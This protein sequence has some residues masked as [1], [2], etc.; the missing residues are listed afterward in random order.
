MPPERQRRFPGRKSPSSLSKNLSQALLHDFGFQV[1]VL[2]KTAKEMKYVIE[3]NP[4]LK[5]R[6]IDRNSMS[7]FFPRPRQRAP[8]KS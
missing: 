5:E 8:R 4:F 7:L 1:P 6:G 3:G 2:I